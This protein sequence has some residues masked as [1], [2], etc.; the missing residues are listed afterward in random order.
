MPF[1]GFEQLPAAVAAASWSLKITIYAAG[2]SGTHTFDAKC[3]KWDAELIAGGASGVASG[4]GNLQGGGGG[5]AG[6]RLFLRDKADTTAL[7][8]SVGADAAAVT[9][10]STGF[11]AGTP[12]NDTTLGAYTAYGGKRS[13]NRN[14]GS[15]GGPTSSDIGNGG[16]GAGGNASVDTY[17]MRPEHQNGAAGGAGQNISTT[18]AAGGA[19]PGVH[20]GAGGASSGSGPSGGG[21][22]AGWDGPGGAGGTYNAN[23]SDGVGVG[24]GGGGTGVRSSGTLTSG[25]GKG[26]RITIY[27]LLQG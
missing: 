15:G 5:G 4:S 6:A 20:G 9:N 14:G 22:G 10:S 19:A 12:G 24:S 3:V 25:K 26:G 16:A 17:S 8:Y 13:T 21:G 18:G 23:G 27:E 2:E 1:D 7:S 11:T